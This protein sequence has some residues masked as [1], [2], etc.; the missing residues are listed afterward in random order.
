MLW[1]LKKIVKSK[2]LETSKSKTLE[3][4]N[5]VKKEVKE[6]KTGN[7]KLM[8]D[9][10]ILE[11][12]IANMKENHSSCENNNKETIKSLLSNNLSFSEQ[13]SCPISYPSISSS[14]ST[15]ASLALTSTSLAMAISPI[16]WVSIL[17]L[18]CDHPWVGGLPSWGWWVTIDYTWQLPNGLKF[19]IMRVVGDY[20]VDGG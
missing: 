19:V 9:V 15:L 3:S 10:K 6:L 16:V 4:V 13:K 8:Q 5:I 14:L 17:W 12:E 18:V 7:K 2:K 11:K 20:P 1:T